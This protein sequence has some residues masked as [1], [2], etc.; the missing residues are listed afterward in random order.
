MADRGILVAVLA[1][2]TMKKGKGRKRVGQL[3][4]V[5]A[6]HP[7]AQEAEA[8]A[9]LCEASLVYIERPCLQTNK[10][11]SSNNKTPEL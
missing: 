11:N 5:G 6:F 2:L 10:Q 1:C 9:S 8:S 3:G 4:C 7:S